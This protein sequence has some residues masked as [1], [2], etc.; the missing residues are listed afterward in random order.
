MSEQ[1]SFLGHLLK[2]SSDVQAVQ[3]KTGK[4]TGAA[5]REVARQIAQLSKAKGGNP[6]SGKGVTK[7]GE[8]D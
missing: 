2:K 8:E 6:L 4:S 3:N 5:Q 1:G 7:S